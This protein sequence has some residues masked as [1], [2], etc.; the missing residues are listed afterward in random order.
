MTVFNINILHPYNVYYF[1]HDLELFD[2]CLLSSLFKVGF[3]Y[4]CKKAV[5]TRGYSIVIIVNLKP[6][7]KFNLKLY[8][9]IQE[10][11]MLLQ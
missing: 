11:C 9:D 7:N 1:G 5:I 6:N 3:F 4:N 10:Y 8:R 2:F